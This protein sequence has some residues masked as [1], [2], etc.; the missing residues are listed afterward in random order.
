[1]PGCRIPGLIRRNG[2]DLNKFL[3]S[4]PLGVREQTG[5]VEP[6]ILSKMVARVR[7]DL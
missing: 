1:M 6:D 5:R 7:M 4:S 2:F 3:S